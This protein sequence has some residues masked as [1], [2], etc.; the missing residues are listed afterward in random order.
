MEKDYTVHF[1]SSQST[2]IAL[3]FETLKNI[4]TE[5]SFRFTKSGM[6]IQEVN[7]SGEIAI[8]LNIDKSFFDYYH[9]SEDT[10]FGCNSKQMGNI[11]KSFR[12]Q[13]SVKFFIL[14]SHKSQMNIHIQDT[15]SVNT[16]QF[17]C[18]KLNIPFQSVDLNSMEFDSEIVFGSKQFA[19][20]CKSF[21]KQDCEKIKIISIDGET[22][23]E[24]AN[25]NLKISYKYKTDNVSD[26][27]LS[28]NEPQDI[29]SNTFHTQH[30]CL[31][32]KCHQLNERV[33]I[34]VKNDF[35]MVL[36]YDIGENSSLK[37]IF[38]NII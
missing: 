28:E 2:N 14:N 36:C 7:R 4:F 32:A 38:S 20:D 24:S 1:I 23:F 5:F 15:H 3:I 18:A 9:C 33:K 35:P 27:P 12:T 21:K 25:P 6:K 13:D 16:K 17:E 8:I 10:V 22:I 31:I 26:Q 29:I 37:C 11:A 30:L 34:C 19:N